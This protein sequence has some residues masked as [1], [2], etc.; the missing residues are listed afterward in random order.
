MRDPHVG[1]FGVAALVLVLL[2]KF[3]ALESFHGGG[4]AMAILGACA[5]GRTLILVPAGLSRYARPEG[6]GRIIIDSAT[7]G[8]AHGAIALA[9]LVSLASRG[10]VGMAASLAPIGVSL[11]L[12]R[13]ANRR[14]GGVTGDILGALVELGELAYLLA[15]ATTHPS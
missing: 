2:G 1:S 6:T 5:L 15:L 8:D 11:G 10:A 14:L 3:A 12:T 13:L 7:P 9:L 4:R